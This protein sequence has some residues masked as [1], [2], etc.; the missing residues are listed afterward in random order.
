MSSRA[1]LALY[2][3]FVSAFLISTPLVILYTAGYRLNFE[4]GR[5]LKTGILSL[6]TVPRGATVILD[7]KQ[8]SDRTPAVVKMVFPGEHTVRFEK[9]GFSSWEKR[10]RVSTGST[11]FATDVAM[12]LERDPLIVEANDVRAQAVHA[13]SGKAAFVAREGAWDEVWVYDGGEETLIARYPSS[14]VDLSLAWSRDGNKLSIQ[15]A[16]PE[17]SLVGVDGAATLS[18][19]SLVPGMTG[20][21]WDAASDSRFFARD[22]RGVVQIDVPHGAVERLSGRADAVE[23]AGANYLEAERSGDQTA[24]AWKEGDVSVLLA[25]VP[26]GDYVF[27]PS[28]SGIVMMRDAGRDRI[29]LLDD[30][31][32]GEPILLQADARFWQW[33]ASG[34][35]LLYSDGFDLHIYHTDSHSDE[36]V[37]RVSEPI[38]GISWYPPAASVLYAQSSGVYAIELDYRD[39][40]NVTELANGTNIRDVWVDGR[41]RTAYFFGTIDEAQGLW[42]RQLQR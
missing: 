3:L 21:W 4:T 20:G 16:G 1:R 37:T 22:A 13:A 19:R 15:S 24:V 31:R 2:I 23:T 8:I 25:Y 38:T 12:F 27:E 33:D 42:S 39:G 17:W 40:R 36:T 32:V 6:G 41:G 10:L 7:G 11:T 35:Q 30:S 29:V 18:L 9:E 26:T 28:P 5:L 14:S 34:K